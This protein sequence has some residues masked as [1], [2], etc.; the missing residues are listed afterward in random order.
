M[1]WRQHLANLAG[2]A[3]PCLGRVGDRPGRR[4]EKLGTRTLGSRTPSLSGGSAARP[5]PP[6]SSR[7]PPSLA[8][9]GT[10]S[11][12]PLASHG[13]GRRSAGTSTCVPCR[14]GEWNVRPE[15]TSGPATLHLWRFH[16][17][18][19]ASRMAMPPQ[20]SATWRRPPCGNGCRRVV[21]EARA[22]PGSSHGYAMA[23]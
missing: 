20:P 12:G 14:S 11:L 13:A 9:D 2:R 4:S 7:T 15:P 6:P 17:Y 10:G 18:P 21:C 16:S 19:Q 22:L 8:L 3:G 1:V 23:A 5:P